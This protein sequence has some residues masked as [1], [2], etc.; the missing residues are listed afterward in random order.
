[1]V[2]DFIDEHCGFLALTDEEYECAKAINPFAKKFGRAFLQYGKVK[3]T[4][5]VTNVEQIKRVVNMAELKYPPQDG[6]HHVWVFDHSSCHTAMADNALDASK[7]DVNPHGKQHKLRDT[8]WG[9][10]QKMCFEL[11]VPKGTRRVLQERR[12]DTSHM[13]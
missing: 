9:K 10:V 13:G 3:I 11:G 5:L 2:S 6:W 1:M 8:V 12:I 7:M 4:G